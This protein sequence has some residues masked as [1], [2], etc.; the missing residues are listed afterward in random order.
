LINGVYTIYKYKV[1]VIETR[2]CTLFGIILDQCFMQVCV[3][4][5]WIDIQCLHKYKLKLTNIYNI[6]LILQKPNVQF[7]EIILSHATHGSYS[8]LPIVLVYRL[9]IKVVYIIIWTNCGVETVLQKDEYLFYSS[10][11]SY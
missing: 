4:G 8:S 1:Q 7:T 5:C 3:A 10:F 11:I 6:M 9:L 2:L